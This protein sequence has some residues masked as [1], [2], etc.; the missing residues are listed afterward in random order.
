MRYNFVKFGITANLEL[1]AERR[2]YPFFEQNREI[3]NQIFNFLSGPK[4]CFVMTGMQG[5]GKSKILHEA[6]SYLNNDVLLFRYK[7][8]EATTIDDILLNLTID[9][10]EYQKS[11]DIPLPKTNTKDFRE[12][13]QTYIKNINR[14]MLLVLE[15]YENVFK[16]DGY[17]ERQRN[18][19]CT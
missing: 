12:K 5:V 9:F 1:N 10:R 8:Y 14:P 3:F 18:R 15:S 17:Y 16:Y 11:L 7:M 19:E 4:A 6:I 2:D 13:I